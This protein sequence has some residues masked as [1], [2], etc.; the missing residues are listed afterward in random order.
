MGTQRL[1]GL[2][3]GPGQSKTANCIP[4]YPMITK[5]CKNN[6]TNDGRRSIADKSFLLSKDPVGLTVTLWSDHSFS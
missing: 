2:N 1:R 4:I 5:D 3:Q 6:G